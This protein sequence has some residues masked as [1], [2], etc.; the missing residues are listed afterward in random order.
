MATLFKPNSSAV[1]L[2][3]CFQTESRLFFVLDYVNCGDLMFYV[4]QQGILPEE[5]AR[6]YSAEISLAFNYLHQQ[7]ILYRNLKLDNVLLDAE[8][9]IKLTDYWVCKEGLQPGDMTHTF[10]G[11]PNYLAPEIIREEEYGF[12]MDWWT[13]GVLV[14]EM[15]IGKSPFHL[16]ENFYNPYENS[17]DYLLEVILERDIFIPRCLSVRATIILEKFLNR[18]PNER[19]GCHPQRGF[20]DVQK[21]PFFRN[22]NWDM[23]EQK[24]VVPL[25]KP[26]ISGEFGLYNFDP[27]FMNK[28]VWLTPDDNDI[29]R[30]T[31]GHEFEGFEYINHLTMSEEEWV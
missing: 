27:Q 15:L 10:C 12:S 1:G 8:G 26:N 29:V 11:T 16:D 14:Y 3:S 4:Q 19:L 22:V 30:K 20:A 23:M 7:G 9:H 25:F 18:N 17:I 6:F 31:D 13:L 2:H 21:H 24:Q 5:H 28:P